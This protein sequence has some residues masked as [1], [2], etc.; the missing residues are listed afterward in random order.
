MVGG[1]AF[2]EVDDVAPFGRSFAVVVV[3]R[4]VVCRRSCEGGRTR[5][6]RGAGMVLTGPR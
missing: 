5:T 1:N 6:G 4:E 3:L 2:D